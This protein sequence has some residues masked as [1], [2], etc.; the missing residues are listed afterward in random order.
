MPKEESIEVEGVVT[1]ALA[2][3]SF[4]VKLENGHLVLAHV[5]GK[6]RKNFIRIVPGDKVTV[7][8]SPYD[9]TRGRIVYRAR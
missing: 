6:M 2:N 8:I 7:E 3:T 9:L 1:Q 5:G 4:R